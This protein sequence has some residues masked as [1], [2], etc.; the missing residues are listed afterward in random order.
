MSGRAEPLSLLQAGRAAAQN[1][2]VLGKFRPF[3]SDK[4]KVLSF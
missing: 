1:V 3:S 2:I 4:R